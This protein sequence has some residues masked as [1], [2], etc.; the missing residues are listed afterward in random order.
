MKHN[1]RLRRGGTDAVLL[2]LISGALTVIGI[3][4]FLEIAG[5]PMIANDTLHIAHM[6][7]GGLFMFI[8]SALLL[9][10]KGEFVIDI[11]AIIVGIGWGFFID[12]LGKYITLDNNYHFK[13]TAAIVYLI[14]LIIYLIIKLIEKR[15]K[16]DYI[17]KLYHL[18]EMLD[19][20]A[21]KDFDSFEKK[22]A[23]QEID[24]LL[25]KTDDPDKTKYLTNMRALISE[26]GI[27]GDE[28]V[29]LVFFDKVKGFLDN[30]VFSIISKPYLLLLIK[31][32]AVIYILFI[33]ASAFVTYQYFYGTFDFIP[34]LTARL[35]L[36]LPLELY[37]YVGISFFR[38]ISAIIFVIVLSNISTIEKGKL[39]FVGYIYL[40]NIIFSDMIG[41][42]FMIF[43]GFLFSVIHFLIYLFVSKL[44]KI[45]KFGRNKAL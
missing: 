23:L 29:D 30:I 36:V 11:S 9:M 15:R 32:F 27:T 37:V 18:H 40:I 12:E 45:K 21:Q 5:Y 2:M 20:I 24:L 14:F 25:K 16:K 8:G 41:Y 3:R 13:P 44:I 31:I 17:E 1:I 10:Y 35:D 38:I 33:G 39:Q 7:W 19:E 22:S 4:I 43:L 26:A 6:L 34:I 42:Y 28:K